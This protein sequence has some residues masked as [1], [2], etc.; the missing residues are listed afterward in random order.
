MRVCCL[1]V[2]SSDLAHQR[3]RRCEVVPSGPAHSLPT[4][5]RILL[6]PV[7]FPRFSLQSKRASLTPVFAHI[8]TGAATYGRTRPHMGEPIANDL[9][10][11]A[12][13]HCPIIRYRLLRRFWGRQQTPRFAAH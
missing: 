7:T 9:T 10:R 5:E 6:G 8:R 3:T 4:S 13:P 12:L 2:E 11:A 1:A